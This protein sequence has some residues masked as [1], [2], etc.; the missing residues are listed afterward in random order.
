MSEP[1]GQISEWIS[2]LHS[3][4]CKPRREGK[5]W[6][7]SCPASLHKGGN[8][9]NPALHIEEAKGGKV[10]ATCHAGC[11]FEDVRAALGLDPRPSNGTAWTP[12]KRER[13]APA[14]AP[15]KVQETPPVENTVIN[16]FPYHSA[17]GAVLVTIARRDGPDGKKVG[18]PWREPKGVEARQP[19]RMRSLTVWAGCQ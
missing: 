1:A 4:D 5:G 19:G 10:L 8:K 13:S 11:T 9:K 16:R 14:R 3:R 17:D 2:A 12:R 7:A 6:R 18:H 15:A